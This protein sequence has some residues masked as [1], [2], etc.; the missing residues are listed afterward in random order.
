MVSI[1]VPCYN[2]RKTIAAVISNLKK[3]PDPKQIIIVDDGSADGTVD[4]LRS[5]SDQ[6]DVIM[7]HNE[8]KGKGEALRSGIMMANK[9][10][11]VFQDADLE[12]N[13]ED[14]RKVVDPVIKGQADVCYGSRFLYESNLSYITRSHLLANKFLTF[15]TNLFTGLHLTDMETGY[16]AFKS[17]ILK[18]ITLQEHGFGIEPEI[19]CKIAKMGYGVLEVPITYKARS[20]AEGKKITFK[21][22]LYAIWCVVKYGI[23]K[24]KE[25]E[26]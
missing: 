26:N 22:G 12:Y 8:N 4:V 24:K 5:L 10:V 3:L 25:K 18:K 17:K 21:D 1:I 19:T 7:Y 20:Y 16:K 11:I 15:I 14:I 2:D 23:F 6:V 13:S 9:P